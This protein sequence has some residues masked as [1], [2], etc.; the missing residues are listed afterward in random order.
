MLSVG[1][2]CRL[3]SIVTLTDFGKGHMTPTEIAI[4]F[5]DAINAKDVER[6]ADLMTDDH[7]FIEVTDPNM[8]EKIR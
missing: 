7:K 5:V 6:L 1:K 2:R 4:A 3:S 8:K